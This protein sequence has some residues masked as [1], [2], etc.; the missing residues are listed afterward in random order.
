MRRRH[1]ALS[2]SRVTRKAV[3]AF[4]PFVGPKS[5]NYHVRTA[6]TWGDEMQAV[7][8]TVRSNISGNKEMYFFVTDNHDVIQGH[9]AEGQF[10]ELEELSIIACYFPRGGVFVDVGANVGNHAIYVRHYLHPTQVIIIEPNPVTISILSINVALNSLQRL[11]DMTHLGCDPSDAPGNAQTQTPPGNLGGAKL[12]LDEEA[13]GVTLICGDD[14]L[15]E[16]RVDFIKMDIERIG[17]EALAGL[18]MTISKWR[19]PISLLRL[20]TQTLRTLCHVTKTNGYEIV[21]KYRRYQSSVIQA[22]TCYR[23]WD[24]YLSY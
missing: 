19:A 21:S 15:V 6:T 22:P 18:A 24:D 4:L 23:G 7:D 3:G 13:D 10:Y 8:G 2:C 14:I 11:V 12:Q 17:D 16:R 20:T 9:R 1:Y 5:W